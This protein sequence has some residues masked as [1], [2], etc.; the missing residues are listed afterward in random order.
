MDELA[1]PVRIPFLWVSGLDHWREV[2][3]KR[4]ERLGIAGEEAADELG[5]RTGTAKVD[6]EGQ[7]PGVGSIDHARTEWITA[8]AWPARHDMWVPLGEDN[9][10]AC[11]DRDR[12]SADGI[13]ETPAVSDDM[14]SD[15]MP[16]LGQD[17]RGESLRPGRPAT[18]GALATTSKNVAPV[19]RTVLNTLDSASAGIGGHA[20]RSSM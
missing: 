7:L 18:D 1:E 16:A 11:F 2:I 10:F 8:H 6:L 9:D 4:I 14:I 12:L 3:E 17:L 15:Q 13:S 5:L 19:S 20:R